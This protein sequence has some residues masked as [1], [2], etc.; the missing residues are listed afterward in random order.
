MYWTH[1]MPREEAVVTA[2]KFLMSM[3]ASVQLDLQSLSLRFWMVPHGARLYS[4]L[5]LQTTLLCFLTLVPSAGRGSPRG[6][7]AQTKV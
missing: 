5:I 4:S 3:E 2:Q 6:Q 7:P 1:L